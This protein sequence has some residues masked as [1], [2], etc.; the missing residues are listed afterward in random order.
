MAGRRGVAAR[1]VRQGVWVAG[2]ARAPRPRFRS[3]PLGSQLDRSTRVVL[4]AARRAPMHA[5]AG[6]LTLVTP[7]AGPIFGD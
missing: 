7:A 4:R 5:L 3:G 1:R 6:W 2:P